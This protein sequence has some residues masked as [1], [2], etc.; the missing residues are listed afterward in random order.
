MLS[1]I[2]GVAGKVVSVVTSP[3]AEAF[4]KKGV[5]KEDLEAHEKLDAT[6]FNFIDQKITEIQLVQRDNIVKFD[7]LI[8][9]VG[10]I[11]GKL[12]VD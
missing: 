6:R 3:F 1:A 9:G 2:V 7:T 12:G 11:K 8:D 4:F 10:K 5:T